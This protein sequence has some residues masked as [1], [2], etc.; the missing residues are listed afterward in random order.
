MKIKQDSEVSVS[1][2]GNSLVQDIQLSLDVWV[3]IYW[4]GSPVSN[5]N[6]NVV[7]AILGN[8]GEVIFGDPGFPML[9]QSGGR[10]VF[11]EC[12]RV[13]VLVDDCHARSPWLKD[14]RSDPWFEDEPAAQV[15]ASDFVAV[16]VEGYITLA[17]TKGQ[18][19]RLHGAQQGNRESREVEEAAAQH[20]GYCSVL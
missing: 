5:G 14:G 1:S 18:R 15:Y 2:P 3:S 4:C 9:R 19:S 13:G 8:L 17:E 11:A 12:L 6:S 20:D 10:S 16:V 7:Q